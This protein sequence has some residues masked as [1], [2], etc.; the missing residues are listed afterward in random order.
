MREMAN[1]KR[2]N[3]E[4]KIVN[5]AAVITETFQRTMGRN[6]LEAEK[7]G[8]MNRIMG[9][10]QQIKNLR[11]EKETY[12]QTIAEIDEIIAAIPDETDTE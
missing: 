9:I 5:G 2:L 10:D 8:Y 6:E 3:K 1:T 4:H 11:A 7:M 12:I